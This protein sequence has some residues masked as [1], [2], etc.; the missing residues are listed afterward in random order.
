MKLRIKADSVRLRLTRSE[1]ESIGAGRDVRETTHFAGGH[2]LEY[3]L[4]PSADDHL[5]ARFE[6][7]RLI[8]RA[9]AAVLVEWAAG[10]TVTVACP[11]AVGSP[12]ILV[13]KDFSCLSPRAGDDDEDAFPHPEEGTRTC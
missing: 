7:Q 8:V 10:D 11:T 3:A 2:T 9:P 5:E 12:S 13:E 4:E 1:V 6:G